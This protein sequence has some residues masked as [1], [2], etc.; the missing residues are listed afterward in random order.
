MECTL[1]VKKTPEHNGIAER[2]IRTIAERVRC[3]LFEGNL[4][5]ELWAEAAV[6]SAFLRELAASKSQ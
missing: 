2:M 6:T 1:T 4:P 3:V 5:E